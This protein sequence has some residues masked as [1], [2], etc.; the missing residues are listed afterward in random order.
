M[1]K[2]SSAKSGFLGSFEDGALNLCREKHWS[3]RPAQ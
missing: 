3:S 1:R 2:Y